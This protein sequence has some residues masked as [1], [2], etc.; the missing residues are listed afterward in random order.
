MTTL[1][2]LAIEHSAPAL[3]AA[4]GRRRADQWR[5]SHRNRGS[6]RRAVAKILPPV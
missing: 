1:P 2:A 6:A 5:G 4:G 3:P